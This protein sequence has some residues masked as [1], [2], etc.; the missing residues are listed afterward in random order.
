MSDAE[1]REKDEHI[2]QLYVEL[3][4]QQARIDRLREEKTAREVELER[5]Y[6]R[7]SWKLVQAL[8]NLRIA[9]WTRP[10]QTW[11]RLRTPAVPE[12]AAAPPQ[13][14]GPAPEPPPQ[15]VIPGTPDEP[16]PASPREDEGEGAIPARRPAKQKLPPVVQGKLLAFYETNLT[17][18]AGGWNDAALSHLAAMGNA[19]GQYDVRN[20]AVIRLH[21][22][23]AETMGIDGFCY[24]YRSDAMTRTFEGPIANHKQC[25]DTQLEYCLCWSPDSEPPGRLELV[26]QVCITQFIEYA[27][28][29]FGDDRYLE[30]NGR[31][32]VIVRGVGP[33]LYHKILRTWRAWS[34]RANL[35]LEIQGWDI[36]ASEGQLQ[37]LPSDDIEAL[38]A[39]LTSDNSLYSLTLSPDQAAADAGWMMSLVRS[40]LGSGK[41]VMVDAWNRWTTGQCLEAESEPWLAI[42]RTLAE[43]H[44]LASSAAHQT[45]G[46]LVIFSGAVPVETLS[47]LA[48]RLKRMKVPTQQLEVDETIDAGTLAKRLAPLEQQGLRSALVLGT[49]R[50]VR[51]CLFERGWRVER[52]EPAALDALAE[53]PL[54][55]LGY[56]RP[57]ISVLV[58]ASRFRSRTAATRL[59]QDLANQSLAALEIFLPPDC[60]DVARHLGLTHARPFDGNLV[61]VAGEL[62]GDYVWIADG[63]DFQD[64]DWL[65]DG[66]RV[67]G[68]P[69][70][71]GAFFGAPSN[72]G[73]QLGDRIAPGSHFYVELLDRNILGKFSHLLLRTAHLQSLLAESAG[74]L[75]E[76][77]SA[78]DWLL[79]LLLL[80]QGEIVIGDFVAETGREDLAVDDVTADAMRL[81]FLN[82][83]EISL[84]ALAGTLRV[85]ELPAPKRAD[86]D[87]KV[88]L[89]AQ[90]LQLETSA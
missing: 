5:I 20:P 9:L 80:Q 90:S 17:P 74:V 51:E 1:L 7:L 59:L 23:A 47:T 65:R 30:V 10:I 33:R 21:A 82:Q 71:A 42:R 54:A 28:N 67:I 57:S 64:R 26:E 27:A 63:D 62:A 11:Q 3:Q 8:R 36:T 60:I 58:P 15:A 89:L 49:P 46:V 32:L 4:T 50:L 39:A 16:V 83:R 52:I 6:G 53:L 14:P 24:H 56:W 66:S 22:R 73:L 70:L 40:Q 25:L 12:G 31:P 19:L 18:L 75:E 68:R 44:Q 72:I 55:R 37:P 76:F 84:G 41:V 87:R 61:S 77:D 34:R 81:W 43:Q 85:N 69:E 38:A 29:F 2:R 79:W 35:D 86:L 88:N 78:R 13:P 45:D 48:D